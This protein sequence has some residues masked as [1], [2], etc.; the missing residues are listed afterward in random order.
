[1]SQSKKI[2][3]W[4]AKLDSGHTHAFAH[5]G[6]ARAGIYLNRDV[7]WL[8]NRDNLE[9]EF[10]DDSIIISEQWLVTRNGLSNN[11]PLRKSSQ[12]FINYVGN[13]P[14]A[15]DN[16][17][18][19]GPHHYIDRVGRLIEF[20]FACDWG[21]HGVPDKAWEYKFEKEK[22]QQLPNSFAHFD[23]GKEYDILYTLWASDLTPD[24]INFEDRFTP[25]A[26]PKY[27]FFSGGISRGWGNVDDGNESYY[28]SFIEECKKNNI[29][30]VYNNSQKTPVAHTEL[31][32]W[33]L[34]SFLPVDFRPKNH[35]VNNYVSDRLMKNVSYGQLPI[36]NS[37]AAYEFFD[38]DAAYS[39]DVKELFYIA[40]EMQEDSKTKDKILNQMKKIK[41]Y[42][43]FVSR[44][45]DIIYIA[46][47]L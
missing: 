37:K 13:K 4:G 12:Y 31:K 18:N 27:A 24:E 7:Y 46:E 8:D 2:I 20:R 33:T 40:K 30:F 44:L 6:F 25:F 10:F 45:K 19:P 26:E 15:P 29:D 35:L 28:L 34:E 5:L 1:M 16:E 43:T 17:M 9:P 41:E 36:T 38:G 21:I 3:I 47:S 32:K 39:S 23:K 22:Y 14:A 42:H 11:L